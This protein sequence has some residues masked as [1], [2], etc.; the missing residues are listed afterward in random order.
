MVVHGNSPLML[1]KVASWFQEELEK[2][3]RSNHMAQAFFSHVSAF[4]FRSLV[5]C[6]DVVYML[7]RICIY[8]RHIYIYMKNISNESSRCQMFKTC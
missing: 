5:K 1:P 6:N 3:E 2:L 4:D 8:T 7:V